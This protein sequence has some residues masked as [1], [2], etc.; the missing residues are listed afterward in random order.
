MTSTRDKNSAE[1][2]ALEQHSLDKRRAYMPFSSYSVPPTTLFAGDGLIMG[3]IRNDQLSY[4]HTDIENFLLGVG[5]TNLVNPLPPVVPLIKPV[6]SLTII[7][8]I[9]LIMPREMTVEKG[10][11]LRLFK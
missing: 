4:N 2:Y 1:N 10:Q 9:P 11:R 5:S 6:A 8:R 7:D 3:R